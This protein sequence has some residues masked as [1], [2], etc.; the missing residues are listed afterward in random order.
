MRKVFELEDKPVV[1]FGESEHGF[2]M[3]SP[4]IAV[5]RIGFPGRGKLSIVSEKGKEPVSMEE[6]LT[7]SQSQ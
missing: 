4:L 6:E 2:V 5:G 1:V 3:V 7:P